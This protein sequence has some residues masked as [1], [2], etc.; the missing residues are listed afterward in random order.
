VPQH[1]LEL[2]AEADVVVGA[3]QFK[4]H[5]ELLVVVVRIHDRH[6]AD[7]QSAH[8]FRVPPRHKDPSTY[9]GLGLQP[10]ILGDQGYQWTVIT[11][12]SVEH[13]SLHLLALVEIVSQRS[14]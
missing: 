3:I 7:P 2:G 12:V 8:W 11:R 9:R 4:N 5:L 14:G 6:A 10:I 13:E 1:V